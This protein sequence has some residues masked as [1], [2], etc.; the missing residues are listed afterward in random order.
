MDRQKLLDTDDLGT[1]YATEAAQLPTIECPA[2]GSSTTD[3]WTL[4]SGNQ[5]ENCGAEIQLAIK[6]RQK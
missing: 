1:L 2:C 4:L 6:W 5:C 3:L